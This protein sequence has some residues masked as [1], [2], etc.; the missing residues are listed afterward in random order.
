MIG[1]LY[2]PADTPLRAIVIGGCGG[3]VACALTRF[4][5]PGWAVFSA[6]LAFV[7]AGAA[8]QGASHIPWASQA[9][10]AILA[11]CAWTLGWP[12]ARWGLESAGTVFEECQEPWEGW[13]EAPAASLVRGLVFTCLV[14]LVMVP[15]IIWWFPSMPALGFPLAMLISMWGCAAFPG[16]RVGWPVAGVLVSPLAAYW[17]AI[18][19]LKPVDH[20]LLGCPLYP[21]DLGA[22]APPD[23]W[24]VTGLLLAGTVAGYWLTVWM[25]GFIYRP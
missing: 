2:G 10:L 5:F 12:L 9:A 1:L 21:G 15:L 13:E 24:L 4:S 6:S 8:H 16:V 25:Q 22:L 17:I 20:P 14:T 19:G 11:G 3:A 18:D 7:A 23:A